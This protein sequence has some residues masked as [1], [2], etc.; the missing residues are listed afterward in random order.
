MCAVQGGLVLCENKV[1]ALQSE[2]VYMALDEDRE[3]NA[4][5]EVWKEMDRMLLTV[6]L[7]SR[8]MAVRDKPGNKTQH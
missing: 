1:W 8:D 2:K 6:H 7:E 3:E 5:E 4:Q